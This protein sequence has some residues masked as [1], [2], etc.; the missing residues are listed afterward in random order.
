M[1]SGR[2]RTTLVSLASPLNA[3]YAAGG[4][5]ATGSLR[6]LRHLRNDKLIGEIDLYDFLLRG[7]RGD[8]DRL[9]GGDTLLVRRRG[10]RW[11]CT[12]AVKPTEILTRDEKTLAAGA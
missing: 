1:C 4:P 8:D 11:R 9:Q 3:L 10:L 6:V 7:V 5:T 2:V 12:G